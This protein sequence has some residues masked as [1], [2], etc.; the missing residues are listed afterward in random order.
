MSV[1]GRVRKVLGQQLRKALNGLQGRPKESGVVDARLH[2]QR[3]RVS[4]DP[5]LGPF[6]SMV[7][8]AAATLARLYA[9]RSE[10]VLRADDVESIREAEQL[11]GWMG[12]PLQEFRRQVVER[13]MVSMSG[14]ERQEDA[15]RQ[16]EDI[17]AGKP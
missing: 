17:L 9:S 6:D 1:E 13:A 2:A 5:T 15:R 7:N 16:L 8:R 4:L 12:M 14:I 11:A 3:N 10:T